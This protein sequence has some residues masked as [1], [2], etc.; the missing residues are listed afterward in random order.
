MFERL[1]H[2]VNQY[3]KSFLYFGVGSCPHVQ[4]V[5]QL[6]PKWDQLLP[7]FVRDIY[8]NNTSRLQVVHVDPQFTNRRDF[9]IAY[10][11][12]HLP[13]SIFYDDENLMVWES[14]R[15]QVICASAHFYHSRRYNQEDTTWFLESLT[16]ESLVNGFKLVYQEYTGEEI[17]EIYHKL[18]EMCDD[19]LRRRFQ[20]QIL[21]DVSY[22]SDVGCMTDMEKYK[23]FYKENGDFLNL[24]LY[25]NQ[26]LYDLINTNPAINEILF[27]KLLTKYR[28]LLNDI[29]VD[30][31]RKINGD[32]PFYPNRYGYSDESTPEEILHCLETELFSLAPQLQKLG[33]LSQESLEKLRSYFKEA[34]SMDRYKWYDQVFKLIKFEPPPFPVAQVQ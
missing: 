18:Y 8:Q 12:K 14:D 25:T 24:Q 27:K 3:P 34:T 7:C 16:E 15:I 4:T 28:M 22:G 19:N 20:R 26:E 13:G 5:E 1:L 29:H 23:P 31:R 33:I 10:F 17:N 9:L 6:T 2:L 21:F 32:L 11:E 30:Y